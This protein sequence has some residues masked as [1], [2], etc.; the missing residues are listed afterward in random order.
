[1]TLFLEGGDVELDLNGYTIFADGDAIVEGDVTAIQVGN[2][3][4]DTRLTITD[5]SADKDGGI[6]VTNSDPAS[7]RMT[8]CIDIFGN[9]DNDNINTTVII[10]DGIFEAES[11]STRHNVHVVHANDG[12]ELIINGG[13]LTAEGLWA[14]TLYIWGKLTVTDGTISGV[15][16][17]YVGY[18]AEILGGTFIGKNVPFIDEEGNEAEVLGSGITFCQAEEESVTGVLGDFTAIADHT[19]IAVNPGAV[20][21]VTGT[22]ELDGA[23]ADMEISAD[24]TFRMGGDRG[25]VV[26]TIW[27][28]IDRELIRPLEDGTPPYVKNFTSARPN[29]GIIDT[30]NGSIILKE[31]F[32]IEGCEFEVSDVVYTGS[33]V[34]PD[35]TVRFNGETLTEGVDYIIAG[36]GYWD[37]DEW[38]DEDA[39]DPIP[40]ELKIE[41]IGIFYDCVDIT[42]FVL[43]DL[44]Q[45][46]VTPAWTEA[47]YTGEGMAPMVDVTL[48]GFVLEEGFHWEW[49]VTDMEGNI[50]PD[51]AVEPG[52]YIFHLLPLHCATESNSFT[53]VITEPQKPELTDDMIILGNAACF[54][55]GYEQTFPYDA[56]DLTEGVDYTVSY[57]NNV[58]A[59]TATMIFE[60]IGDYEG[61]VVKTFTIAPAP[62]Y[63]SISDPS[64]FYT[65]S[66][67]E[68]VVDVFSALD[69]ELVPNGNYTV[70]YA[71]NT[72]PGTGKATVAAFGNYTGTCEMTFHI[73]CNHDSLSPE[74][75]CTVCGD[76]A[77][78]SIAISGET[79]H[80][81]SGS[82][83]SSAVMDLYLNDRT[84]E[85]TITLLNDTDVPSGLTFTEDVVTIDL[86]GHVLS[87]SEMN[88][89]AITPQDNC[90]LTITDS[91]GGGTVISENFFQSVSTWGI[92]SHATENAKLTIAGGVYEQPIS[93]GGT[94]TVTGGKF[95]TSVSCVGNLTITGGTFEDG[96]GIGCDGTFNITGGRFAFEV[97]GILAPEYM[98]VLEGGY[99]VVKERSEEPD[100][101]DP[102]DPDEP[103]DPDEPGDIPGGSDDDDDD[104]SSADRPSV[105]STENGKG[106]DEITDEIT[107]TG[108]ANV[109][110]G[111]TTTVP[112]E[113]ADAI[114]S[115][116][117]E[118]VFETSKGTW[119]VDGS[120][121]P[122]DGSE[123]ELKVKTSSSAPAALKEEAKD[124]DGAL[125]VRL[126]KSFADNGVEAALEV[127]AGK[128]YSGKSA[129][130]YIVDENGEAKL[131]TSV[132]VSKD[133]TVEIPVGGSDQ[134]AVIFSDEGSL[135]E[136]WS[137]NAR[138]E[139]VYGAEDGTA[140]TGWHQ[141][142]DG[143]WYHMDDAGIMT[144]GWHADHNGSWYYLQDSGSMKTGWHKDADGKWY[145]LQDSGSMKANGWVQARGEWYYIGSDGAM[146]TDTVTPDGYRVDADG[147]WIR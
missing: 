46:V 93:I 13:E 108:S 72:K 111:N 21:T 4:N 89:P 119:T 20:V 33:P 74:G 2:E 14:D 100:P 130:I 34:T 73:V 141:D 102:E 69:D 59:G 82:A 68:P 55:N 134:Y 16:A 75:V 87:S 6:R 121:L 3:W 105:P 135:P 76:G 136:G 28:E 67:I 129:D 113:V 52:E 22:P 120:T 26:Y 23:Y 39:V 65:G 133:G 123:L 84:D 56:P 127:K 88:W 79:I 126:D 122:A 51:G 47:E 66:P 128:R 94:I 146:I 1:E 31:V 43:A 9:W 61:T 5:T 15:T 24:S 132:S 63:A 106:W 96:S 81:L 92:P 38:V 44:S 138:G 25:D 145:Y 32:S 58:E 48:D 30:Y 86:N 104:D 60:G 78:A 12:T 17:T 125:N 85:Y 11:A 42:F 116:D 7:E 115:S 77:V 40:Y 37:N 36:T 118:I 49:A 112:G 62:I 10:E 80:F 99:Y 117:A 35:V 8:S 83:L 18:D 109:N 50:L 140:V 91:V 90:D 27:G 70:T 54:Y 53:F 97:S 29:A 142:T 143:K 57:E 137:Q 95:V 139:W 45:A 19:A 131:L 71:D 41:G 114:A 64:H 124:A 103:V 144:T 107:G 147:K 101:E 98:T 110:M